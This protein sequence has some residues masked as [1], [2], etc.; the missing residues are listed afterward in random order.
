M[1]KIFSSE[2]LASKAS[3]RLS[4]TLIPT[5]TFCDFFECMHNPRPVDFG[6]LRGLKAAKATIK[7]QAYV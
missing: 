2:I 7:A 6:S 1:F 3:F 4:A 5:P